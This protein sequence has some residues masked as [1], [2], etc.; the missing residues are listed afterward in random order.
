MF[1]LQFWQTQRKSPL[2]QILSR[3]DYG[4]RLIYTWHC[5]SVLIPKYSLQFRILLELKANPCL[6]L[7]CDIPNNV[8]KALVMHV[9]HIIL[10][11]AICDH[12]LLAWDCKVLLRRILAPFCKWKQK[13]HTLVVE[14]NPGCYP[15]S[16]W[17]LTGTPGE[18]T[19]EVRKCL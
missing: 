3:E 11:G 9:E 14:S 7:N 4:I 16:N 19:W 2:D 15:F 8:Q 12:L 18:N 17:P 13:A 5:T 6:G 10:N 1:L